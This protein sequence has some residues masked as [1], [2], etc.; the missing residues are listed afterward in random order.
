MSLSRHSTHVRRLSPNVTW[1]IYNSNN[2]VNVNRIIRYSTFYYCKR[3]TKKTLASYYNVGL[4]ASWKQMR[5]LTLN[6]FIMIMHTNLTRGSNTMH[7]SDLFWMHILLVN[8]IQY[9]WPTPL[10]WDFTR[11]QAFTIWHDLL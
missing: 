3:L 1:K 7:K 10:I 8:S 2:Y 9:F 6:V 11:K 5:I 4:M